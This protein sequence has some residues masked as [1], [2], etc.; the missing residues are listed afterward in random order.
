MVNSFVYI[1]VSYVIIYQKYKNN[2]FT[3]GHYL[4]NDPGNLHFFKGLQ[5]GKVFVEM[6]N[7]FILL[8]FWIHELLYTILRKRAYTLNVY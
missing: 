6:T 1:Y 2:I 5:N 4:V 7:C 8:C 3:Q